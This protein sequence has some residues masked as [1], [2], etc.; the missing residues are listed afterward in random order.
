MKG[1]GLMDAWVK[2]DILGQSP[3]YGRQELQTSHVCSQINIASSVAT[4]EP[5]ANEVY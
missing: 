5:T 2:S 1:C 4:L 3:S